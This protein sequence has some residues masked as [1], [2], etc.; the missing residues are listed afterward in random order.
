[1]CSCAGLWSG[2]HTSHGCHL[3]GQHSAGCSVGTGTRASVEIL[4]RPQHHAL[5]QNLLHDQVRCLLF[6]QH[7]CCLYDCVSTTQ[8]TTSWQL[9]DKQRSI[10]LLLPFQAAHAGFGVII[11]LHYVC[12]TGCTEVTVRMLMLLLQGL[13]SSCSALHQCLS[14]SVQVL[15]RSDNALLCGDGS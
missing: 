10:Y 2:L 1:M 9:G 3:V 12:L 11:H 13:I 15:A 7:W 14:S 4:Y 5:C 8:G 6:V